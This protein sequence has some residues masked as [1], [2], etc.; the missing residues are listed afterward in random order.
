MSEKTKAWI[1]LLVLSVVWG[2]SYFLIKLALSDVSGNVRL[3]P[4]QLGAVRMTIASGVLLPFFFKLRKT[5][6]KDKI[7]FVAISGFVGNGLPSF[8]FAYA[9]TKLD[10]SI[11]GML[12]SIVPIF[13][14]LIATFVFGFKMKWNHIV[15]MSIGILGAY[16]IMYSKLAGVALTRADLIP[17]AL[18]VIATVC[19]AVSLN[20]IKYKLSGLKPMAITSMA[21]IFAGAPSLVY[22]LVTNFPKEVLTNAKVLEG[23]G[24]VFILAVVGTAIAVYLFNHL[25]KLSTPIFASSVTYFIP[26]VA[27]L[28]GV[29]SGE[30]V[31]YYQ[32]IG[33]AVLISGV[34]LINKK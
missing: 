19:Y 3:T 10:S 1:L 34:L 12:N 26:V 28:L 31:T 2:S 24:F 27:T 22:L 16:I 18:I 33:M 25:I 8:L 7:I 6:P 9:Q 5:I 32:I 23:V 14:I 20:V 15:G 30:S 4:L 21:F 17:F 11:T 29:A 13:A